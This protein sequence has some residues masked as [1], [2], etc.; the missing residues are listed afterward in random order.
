MNLADTPSITFSQGLAD[1]PLP[2]ILPDGREIDPCSLA[3]ALANLSASQVKALGLQIS[4]ISGQRGSTSSA[5]LRLQSSL[6]SRLRQQFGTDG[7]IL[8][9]QTW[10]E[11]VTPSGQRYWEHTAS[12]RRTSGSGC[13]SWPSPTSSLA[14][15]GVRTTD[16]AI[17]EAMRNHG[18][19]LGAVSALTSWATPAARDWRSNSASEEH[20]AKRLDDPR[21]KP[22][23]EQAH[24]LAPWCS[25]TAMDHSRGTAPPRPQDT[26]VP[27]SQQASGLTPSGSNAETGSSGQLNPAFVRWLMGYPPEWC[28][29]AVLATQLSPRLRR[30]S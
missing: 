13:T 25:P 15:K 17:R 28:D 29:C 1:G 12:G 9:Q 26:G 27:L 11:R 2:W 19:D 16:G 7:S 30:N 18:P 24:Q 5:S 23:S 10:R 21:G 8:F 3:H 4:G 22:L 14:D 20:H 6:V